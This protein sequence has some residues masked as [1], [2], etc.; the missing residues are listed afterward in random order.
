ME[1]WGCIT[2]SKNNVNVSG[3][4]LISSVVH[5]ANCSGPRISQCSIWLF[6][7]CALTKDTLVMIYKKH[8]I[9]TLKMTDL[10]K[11]RLSSPGGPFLTSS[12]TWKAVSSQFVKVWWACWPDWHF[13]TQEMLSWHSEVRASIDRGYL[14]ASRK[15]CPGWPSHTTFRSWSYVYC[16]FHLGLQSP[17]S[18]L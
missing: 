3:E 16:E 12:K 7:A 13:H 14:N 8:T 9:K 1:I 5:A 6:N 11:V 18:R 15:R 17:R 2:F 10:R 4:L